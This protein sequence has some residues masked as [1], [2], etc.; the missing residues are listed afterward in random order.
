MR[1]NPALWPLAIA[2]L[3]I[4]ALL[5]AGAGTPASAKKKKK[6]PAGTHKVVI[7]KKNGKKK[8]RCVANPAATPTP[9]AALLAI[10]PSGAFFHQT[11][12]G[13][14]LGPPVTCPTQEFTVTNSGGASSGALSAVTADTKHAAPITRPAYV[15]T[16]NGCTSALPPGGSCKVTVAFDPDNNNGDEQ[17]LGTLTVTG[18]PGGSAQAQLNGLGD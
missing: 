14:C 1:T 2:T 12:G 13:T 17:Y 11:H 7:K 3:L 15:I 18:A 10:S 6:C 4:A 5:F 8:K 9:P 16:A